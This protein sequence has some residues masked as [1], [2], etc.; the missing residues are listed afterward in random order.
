MTEM[1]PHRD[2]AGAFDVIQWVLESTGKASLFVFHVQ[3][4]HVLKV[5]ALIGAD[6]L[7]VGK[8]NFHSRKSTSPL[9]ILFNTVNSLY[10]EGESR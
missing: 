5:L 7:S 1:S 8:Q 6:V 4:Q 2:P 9:L 3:N 10:N